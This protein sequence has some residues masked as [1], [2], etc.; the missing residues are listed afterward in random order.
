MQI[1][2]LELETDFV[3][4]NGAEKLSLVVSSK[5]PPVTS[6]LD[7]EDVKEENKDQPPFIE[8]QD[9]HQQ[10]PRALCKPQGN[11]KQN[12]MVE[13]L[14]DERLGANEASLIDTTGRRSQIPMKLELESLKTDVQSINE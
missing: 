2:N 12:S 3:K 5:A 1:E 10:P 6:D 13:T 4:A 14:A 7:R 11:I 9:F 8:L